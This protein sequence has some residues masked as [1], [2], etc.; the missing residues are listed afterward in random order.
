[1]SSLSAVAKRTAVALFP[2]RPPTCLT[3]ER[4]N[5]IGMTMTDLK[6]ILSLTKYKTYRALQMYTFL[7]KDRG[8][9]WWRCEGLPKDMRL[10]LDKNYQISYGS[11]VEKYESE[12]GMTKRFLLKSQEGSNVECTHYDR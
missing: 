12:D 6:T 5:L 10:W 3:I 4:T 8:M 2:K 11:I 1:M 7:Y 9:K